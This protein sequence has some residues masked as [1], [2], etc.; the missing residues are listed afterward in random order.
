VLYR[1]LDNPE[2]VEP[3]RQEVEAV[4]AEEGWTKAGMDK[5]HKIDSFVR[6]SQRVDVLAIRSS[7]PTCPSGLSS[8]ACL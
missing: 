6:E 3:L 1:L 4:I 5:M 8:D 2:Y 7:S